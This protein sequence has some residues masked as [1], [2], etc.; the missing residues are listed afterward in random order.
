MQISTCVWHWNTHDED[1]NDGSSLTSLTYENHMSLKWYQ[2]LGK[3]R[4]LGLVPTCKELKTV[5]LSL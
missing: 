4:I 2:N 5:P 3:M 1:S